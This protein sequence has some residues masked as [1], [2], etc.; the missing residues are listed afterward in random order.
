MEK[1]FDSVRSI[2]F[3]WVLR[4]GITVAN[5][6]LPRDLNAEYIIV[7]SEEIGNYR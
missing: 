6:E 4:C 5:V 1:Q 3:A 2:R 7:I